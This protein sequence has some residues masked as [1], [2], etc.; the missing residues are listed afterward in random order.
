[1]LYSVLVRQ[2][3]LY[4]KK[5]ISKEEI[6]II[7][8]KINLAYFKAIN[9]LL[10]NKYIVR[11][12]RGFFY[13]PTIEERKL[14][15]STPNFYEAI[16]RAME[17][18]KINNWYFGLES[19]IK[20]NNI[21][22]EVFVIDFII[23][24]TLFRPKPI[25]ILGRKVKFVRL[26]KKLFDFGIKKS[27]EFIIYSDLEK[28]LLDLIHIKKYNGKS[29]KIIKNELVEWHDSSNKLKLHKYSKHYNNSVKNVLGEFND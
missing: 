20:I 3:F 10:T 11:I 29:N 23:S 15:N 28:T 4:N 6:E 25:N 27:G 24:D 9:Y 22:H 18:K 5:Y 7:C 13:V 21:T 26:N 12:L 2:I 8:D 14:F 17:Y 16:F 19:A 1:M